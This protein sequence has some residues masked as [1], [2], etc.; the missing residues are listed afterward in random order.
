MISG[1]PRSAPDQESTGWPAGIPYIIGNEGAERFAF[2]GI[3]SFLTPYLPDVLYA[4]HP[5]F[6]SDPRVYAKAH[7]TCSS[8]RSTRCR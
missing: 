1:V 4:H 8:L 6:T 5:L 3:R 7:S 2:Y